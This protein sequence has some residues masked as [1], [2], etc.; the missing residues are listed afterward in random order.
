MV[1]NGVE[2]NMEWKENIGMEY[3]MSQVWNGRFDVWN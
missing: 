2:W 1:W 3:E